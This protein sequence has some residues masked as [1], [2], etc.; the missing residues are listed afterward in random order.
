MQRHRLPKLTVQVAVWVAVHHRAVSF[1]TDPSNTLVQLEP[2][3]TVHPELLMRCMEGY[4]GR[5]VEV[6]ANYS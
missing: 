1:T 6:Q 4:S 3:W 5:S 2:I